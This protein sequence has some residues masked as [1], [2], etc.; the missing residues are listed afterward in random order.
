M[1]VCGVVG[2]H[3]WKITYF[4]RGAYGLLPEM[5]VLA[6]PPSRGGHAVGAFSGMPGTTPS[7]RGPVKP[8]DNRCSCCLGTAAVG[9]HTEVTG[10]LDYVSRAWLLE[11]LAGTVVMIVGKPSVPMMKGAP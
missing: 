1:R 6:T 3:R 7:L 2:N 9:A 8:Y 11:I 4:V 10:T 5:R